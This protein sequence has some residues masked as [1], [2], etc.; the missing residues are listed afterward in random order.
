MNPA[1][2]VIQIELGM[3]EISLAAAGAS[4]I[5]SLGRE[6]YQRTTPKVAEGLLGKLLVRSAGSGIVVVRIVDVEAY[7][8]VED[9][10]CHTYR[11]RRTQR[12]EAMWGP[13]GHAYVYLIYGIHHCLNVVTVGV[14]IPEAILIRGAA[15]VFGA[16]TMRQRRGGAKSD[17]ELLNGP[18]KLCQAL[19]VTCSDQSSDF[20]IRESGLFIGNDDFSVERC[21]IERRKRVGIDYA[22]EAA[23]W[24]LR[25]VLHSN[26]NV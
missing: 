19:A 7:L 17:R 11:G 2:P 26:D 9:P 13:A 8:G 10:A 6:F 15:P 25:Y 24:P 21:S 22:G 5:P 18:G 4:A 14:G 3:N 12:T 23:E 16:E 1:P 20:T